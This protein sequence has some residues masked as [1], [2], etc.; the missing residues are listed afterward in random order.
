MFYRFQTATLSRVFW[1]DN[2]KT[3]KACYYL[4][5]NFFILFYVGAAGKT[6]F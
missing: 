4:G 2:D 3:I 6:S 5:T 1:N